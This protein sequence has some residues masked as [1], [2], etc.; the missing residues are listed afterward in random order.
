VLRVVLFF[1]VVVN[2]SSNAD[3]DFS[4][5]IK[6]FAVIQDESLVFP[7]TYQSQNNLRLMLD[8][9]K[10][11][12]AWEVHYQINPILASRDLS[13]GD[14][15]FAQTSVGYR[16][17]DVERSLSDADSKN[18]VYQNLD[19][20][21]VQ[22][23]FASG[24]LT[25]GRQAITFGSA[26]I[27]N[28]TDVFIPFDVRTFN[29]EY[30]IGVDAIR[31]QAPMGDLG[32]FDGGL[33]LGNS[34]NESAAFLQLSGNVAGNDLQFAIARFAE[35]NIVGTGVQT[36]LGQFGFWFEIAAVSGD[37]DYVRTS[38]GLDYAFSDVAFGQIEFHHNAAGSDM[39]Q[40]YLAQL[41]T[42]AYQRGGVFLLGKR[43]IMPMFSYQLGAL[44]TINLQGIFNLD[45]NSSFTSIAA[46]YSVVENLDMNFNYYHFT[47]DT[48]ASEYGLSPD[49]AFVSLSYYF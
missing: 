8:E 13:F 25:I 37:D 28:P 10:G 27:I 48:Q 19:R 43:Y 9:S 41:T 2:A 22:F 17:T 16:L 5:Y 12:V 21:N 29:Q 40:D 45:D 38:T 6:T 30:R 1:A 32:E 15:T 35:Q 34:A 31:Y 14:A 4:G 23:R 46:G 36:A 11:R 42:T 49:L 39:P 33:V 26:R 20:L 3:I 47:G 44:W 18:Q 7:R 24:D